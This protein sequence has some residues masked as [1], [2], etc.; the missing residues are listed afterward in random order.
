MTL[1][2]RRICGWALL[3]NCFALSGCLPS[4]QS[5]LD[6]EKDPHF[7]EGKGRVN[8][9]D[10][11][12]AIQ[13]FENA[14]AAN[15]K[16]ASAHFE[17]G[18]LYDQRKAE[19]ATAIYHYA[20]FV[21]AHASG[22]KADRARTRILACKQELAR[23][24]SLAPVTQNMQHEFDQLTEENRRLREEVERWRAYYLRMQGQSNVPSAD[25]AERVVAQPAAAPALRTSQTTASRPADAPSATATPP[26]AA[27]AATGAKTHTVKG[28]ETPSA[29][30]RKYNIKVATLMAANPRTDARHLQVGQTLSIPSP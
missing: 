20:R 17:L 6:E 15:P 10:Y 28:G 18:W 7:L 26:R 11:D 30:A 29:I 23:T 22:E 14:L 5:Q 4:L 8:S 2:V 25:L 24:V 13:S 12:G 21:A 19:P 1:S 27:N 3:L 9:M 16:S